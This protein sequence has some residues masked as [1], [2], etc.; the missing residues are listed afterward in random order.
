VKLCVF[1][2]APPS[3]LGGASRNRRN[4][5]AHTIGNSHRS[6]AGAKQREIKQDRP[7]PSSGSCGKETT[8][9]S[10]GAKLLN[11][12]H[13]GKLGGQAKEKGLA[14]ANSLAHVKG[15]N[16]LAP[17]CCDWPLVSASSRLQKTPVVLLSLALSPGCLCLPVV[18]RTTMDKTRA[19]RQKSG[20]L[21]MG[22]VHQA[23][24]GFL[25]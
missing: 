22:K 1:G 4:T 3:P 25:A 15:S 23:T 7:Q 2:C 13:E 14:K 9:Q 11:S 21:A 20:R 24:G 17:M 5:H 10:G 12:R 19:A 16:T 18:T 6:G 8:C